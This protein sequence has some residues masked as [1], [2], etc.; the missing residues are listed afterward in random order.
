MIFQPD[1]L[2]S[3]T[4]AYAWGRLSRNSNADRCFVPDIS[5]ISKIT[6]HNFT[7]FTYLCH[8]KYSVFTEKADRK[9]NI[10]RVKENN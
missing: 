2:P 10:F 8:H 6:D 4:K 1:G 7:Q 5:W 3:A 9:T